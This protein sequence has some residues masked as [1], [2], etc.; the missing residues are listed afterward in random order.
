MKNSSTLLLKGA[1][2]LIGVTMLAFCI[3]ALPA[4]IMDDNIGMYR[5]ILI[6]MYIPII[7]FFIALF[8]AWVLLTYI[9]KNE[10]FSE[11]SVKA[12][13]KIK[14]CAVVIT[15]LY[16]AGM[17]YIYKVANADDAPGVVAIGLTIIFMSFVVATFA[18]V[19]EKLV[20]NAI[21]IKAE[22]DLTV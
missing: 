18:A 17:P 9:D 14:N 2:I 12:L 15:L 22:N 1:L 19:L 6:G 10:A 20:R 11:L 5:P 7:P 13:K 8:Q 21:D 3:F 4:G 16:A